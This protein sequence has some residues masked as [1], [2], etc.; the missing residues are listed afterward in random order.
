M[1]TVGTLSGGIAHDFNNLLTV[2]NGHAEMALMKL[3]KDAKVYDDLLAITRAGKRAEKVTN[4]LLAFSRKQIHEPTILQINKTIND[5]GRMLR[6]L[7]PANISIKYDLQDN[8]P[9]VKAD[10]NQIEQ[11]LINLVVNARDAIDENNQNNSRRIDI[12]T[13]SVEIGQDFTDSHPGSKKGNYVLI[14]V[15]DSGIGMDEKTKE[16]VFEPFFT[17]KETGKGTGLGLSMVYGIIKQNGGSIFIDSEPNSGTTFKIYWPATE[18]SSNH[19]LEDERD[20]DILAGNE[21]I[22]LVEDDNDVRE[23]VSLAL[24]NFGYN[25]IEAESGLKAIDLIHES[26]A[27]IDL[28]ITDIIMPGINGKELASRLKD[29]I[30]LN[31]VLFVSG[32]SQDHLLQNGS[33]QQGI[34]FLQKPY[35]IDVLIKKVREIL[36]SVN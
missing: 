33:L 20:N 32:Y 10:P 31:R 21:T 1:E 28:M 30:S 9:N 22:L 35:P 5:L 6:R 7:I 36:D 2:I 25:V 29:N 24:K 4:Q 18:E 17:T 27:A 26:D 34:N 12:K 11:I 16:R 13:R 23:L 15:K 19:S 8:I 3:P 14:S